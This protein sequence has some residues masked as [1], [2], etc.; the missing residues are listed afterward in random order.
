MAKRPKK[1]D[2]RVIEM[3]VACSSDFKAVINESGDA[4]FARVAVWAHVLQTRDGEDEQVVLGMIPGDPTTNAADDPVDGALVFA[5]EEP[6][7]MGYCGPSDS[8][9][10]WKKVCAANPHAGESES[11]E[12]E[13]ED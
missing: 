1:E 3:I 8:E 10:A 5:D 7:F 2:G 13:T 11:Q 12:E 6:G 4:T 9:E